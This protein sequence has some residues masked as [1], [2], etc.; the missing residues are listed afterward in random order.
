M[1]YQKLLLGDVSM[2]KS[3][4]N[5]KLHVMPLVY[6][7]IYDLDANGSSLNKAP[8]FSAN[9]YELKTLLDHWEWQWLDIQYHIFTRQKKGTDYHCLIKSWRYAM[10]RILEIADL[11]GDEFV[12]DATSTAWWNLEEQK[13]RREFLANAAIPRSVAEKRVSIRELDKAELHKDGDQ[14]MKSNTTRNYL[15][16]VSEADVEEMPEF[17]PTRQEVTA[18]LRLMMQDY[19]EK[20]YTMYTWGDPSSEQMW[21]SDY[22]NSR[23]AR[24]AHVL[25]EETARAIEY[26]ETERFGRTCDPRIWDRFVKGVPLPPRVERKF[27]MGE[28]PD[29]ADWVDD[30]GS[31][32]SKAPHSED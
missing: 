27:G 1:R 10:G 12:D 32:D 24:V 5:N 17:I 28:R 15:G 22:V 29:D 9:L 4:K 26:D 18:L 3:T 25:G 11:V 14:R 6:P 8:S 2:N 30:D 19:L 16:E 31:D 7:L 23:M 13:D 21:Q 20:E